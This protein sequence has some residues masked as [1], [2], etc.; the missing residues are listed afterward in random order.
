MALHVVSWNIQKG[1]GT[2]F[3]RDLDRTARVLAA[4]EPDVIGLQ[5]VLR[6]EEVDQAMLLARALDMQL[7]WGPARNITGGTFGNALL[8]RG[9]V[10]SHCVHD[11]SVPRMEPRACLEA[12]VST[13]GHMVRM[14]VCHFGLGPRERARQASSLLDVLR[15]APRD[16]PRI[17][18]GD[19]N[20][21]YRGPVDR[22]LAEEFPGGPER[23]ATHPSP[24]PL[25]ALD[26]IAWDD[27][28][29]GSAYVRPVHRASDH[30]LL[31]ATLV[32][33]EVGHGIDRS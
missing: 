15:A 9:E 24:L 10:L 29:Y 7:A 8:V 33:S 19:F 3:R 25:F 20:E 17:A 2:D 6:T 14:F 28:L 32:C 4:L 12:L 13:R 11:L 26:R 31:H 1:I 27:P 16:V 22:A 5:E 18:L 30:R 23:I 21:W